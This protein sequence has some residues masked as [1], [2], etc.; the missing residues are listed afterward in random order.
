[1]NRFWPVVLFLMSQA[2][3]P[4]A[5]ADDYLDALQS[6][7]RKL[8]YL[9]ES[10]SSNTVSNHQ[11]DVSPA[12][13]KALQDISEFEQYYRQTD[14]ATAA[15][16]FKLTQEERLR[17]YHRFKSSRDFELA[18]QMTIELFNQKR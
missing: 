11:K 5:H 1:M 12:E 2:P 18:K 9:D 4:P 15:L 10:R 8:E 13:K 7:A 6:E 3:M 17:I 16:Y 14:S